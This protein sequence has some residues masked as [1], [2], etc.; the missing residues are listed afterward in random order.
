MPRPRKKPLVL[1]KRKRGRSPEDG[2]HH[3]SG[4]LRGELIYQEPQR[5][6]VRDVFKIPAPAAIRYEFGFDDFAWLSGQCRDE[7]AWMIEYEYSDSRA[8]PEALQ[9]TT[10]RLRPGALGK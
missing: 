1:D 10:I 6:H 9:L 2:G 5:E 7:Q 4:A 3:V 8:E